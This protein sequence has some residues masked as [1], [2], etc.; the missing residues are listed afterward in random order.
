MVFPVA[1]TDHCQKKRDTNAQE[2]KVIPELATALVPLL[3][4]IHYG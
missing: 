4:F 1:V 3:G 2:I